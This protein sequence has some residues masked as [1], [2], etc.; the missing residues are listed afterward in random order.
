MDNIILIGMPGVGK[1]TLGVLLAKTL[2][3]TFL[4]TDL[5][6]QEQEGALL[7]DLIAARGIE[8]F[9]DLEGEVCAHL[10]AHRTV[11]ATGGSVVY[12]SQAMAHLRELG[13]VVYLKLG[14]RA[15]AK[16]LGSLKR[17]GVVLRPGQT[18]R[19]LYEERVPLYEQYAHLTIDCS[20]Q[21]VE[22]TLDRVMRALEKTRPR[23]RAAASP[24]AGEA[25]VFFD[26]GRRP[27]APA[28]FRDEA[29]EVGD[30]PQSPQ[31]GQPQPIAGH[32]LADA[33][34]QR[35]GC[36]EGEKLV[37]KA[38]L[39]PGQ[40]PAQEYH[41][42]HHRGEGGQP[43]LRGLLGQQ[44]GHQ[45]AGRAQDHVQR[46]VGAEQ[47]CH[48]APHENPRP[49]AGEQE[50]QHGE[51]LGQAHLD[52]GKGGD[53]QDQGENRVHRRDDGGQRQVSGGKFAHKKTSIL[54]FRERRGMFAAPRT[55][56]KQYALRF[57][58]SRCGLGPWPGRFHFVSG[59]KQPG[60]A[61]L[62]LHPSLRSKLPYG[63]VLRAS[64]LDEI[65][66]N[67]SPVSYHT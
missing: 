16:R 30:L 6:I 41:T 15:L 62:G 24:R 31:Q 64:G 63:P 66:S 51:G 33:H 21:D 19:M 54:L 39:I 10:Q 9:L 20:G 7:R 38:H 37:G 25:A 18:L 67:S 45:G 65:D 57:V 36:E 46:A 5:V 23:I 17:R 8:G 47:V 56:P 3:M 14:Y 26:S 11:V 13:T 55:N 22:H 27:K 44:G 35:I 48:Q 1:S 59:H 58:L 49:G 4:D 34:P 29:A 60:H 43:G 42:A 12:R 28:V 2:G 50:G 52:A 61:G 32:R 53:G 40:H